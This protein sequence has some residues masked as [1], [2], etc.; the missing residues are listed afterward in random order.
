MRK[1][2]IVT[3]SIALPRKYDDFIKIMSDHENKITEIKLD[4]QFSNPSPT[5]KVY[6]Y[7]IFNKYTPNG[8]SLTDSN[9]GVRYRSQKTLKA[10]KFKLKLSKIKAECIKF[11]TNSNFRKFSINVDS[12]IMMVSNH[13]YQFIYK[14]KTGEVVLVAIDN[15]PL[16]VLTEEEQSTLLDKFSYAMACVCR[17]DYQETV[18]CS[19]TPSI[20]ESK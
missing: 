7:G 20:G 8:L 18:T 15:K 3:R 5:V 10:N 14:A 1:R 19:V 9:T 16:G 2:S 13:A 4:I 6:I 11:C 12:L 17:K